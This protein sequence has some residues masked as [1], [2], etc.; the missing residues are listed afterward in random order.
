[1][2][3]LSAIVFLGF[4]ATA[5]CSPDNPTLEVKPGSTVTLQKKD[6]V[7]VSGRL[8]EVKPEH[9]VVETSG[10]R[11]EVRRADVT[12]LKTE[13]ALVSTEPA[14]ASL[15]PVGSTGV[16]TAR[17]AEPASASDPEKRAAGRAAE[18]R[19][20]TLPAGTVL[21]VELTTSVGSDSSSIEDSVR[22]TLRRAV[23]IDGVQ[24]FPAGT[25]VSGHV[26]AAE[27]SARVKGRAR[28]AF[29]FTTIDPPGDA[30]R[31]TMR[32]DTIARLAQATKKQDAAKIGGGAA[33]G[34]IIGGILGGG[35]GAAKGAAIGGA[36]GTGVVLSTRGKE[37]HLPAGTPVSVR[38][39]SPLT[40]RVA[41]R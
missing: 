40:V 21:P 8:V 18:Y 24:A 30:E 17:A 16:D 26:T 11:A 25:P 41:V 27:R 19:E 12:A 6:G 31:L 20:V 33:G 13:S 3:N 2:K 14:P 9:L 28:V 36:A 10:G 32:T 7:T 37:V 34:A 35:D 29:R 15:S 23:T 4:L 22:G 39:T 38:L 1:M 5:A